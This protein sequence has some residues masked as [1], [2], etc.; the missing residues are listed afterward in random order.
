METIGRNRRH[1]KFGD[2]PNG[3]PLA[4]SV[5]EEITGST[6]KLSDFSALEEMGYLKSIDGK[7]D[8][9]GAMF[10]SGLF[11]R[12][13]WTKPSPTV[14]TNFYNPRY[15]LH[16]TENRPFTLRECAR[17]QGFPDSFEFTGAGISLEAGYRLVGNAVPPPLS[18]A[19][20]KSVKNYFKH[21]L[22][23]VACAA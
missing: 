15:F 5:I 6:L 20:A 3:N 21:Q 23:E 12:P 9:K 7:Y 16:P 8:L 11:K 10:C 14:L 19:L 22:V 4:L 1:K 2:I 13:I 17:L 18:R